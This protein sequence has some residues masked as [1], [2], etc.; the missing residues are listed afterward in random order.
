M[1]YRRILAESESYNGIAR[2]LL[3]VAKLVLAVRYTTFRS[4]IGGIVWSNSKWPKI[5]VVKVTSGKWRLYKIVSKKKVDKKIESLGVE[6]LHSLATILSVKFD[7][8]DETAPDRVIRYIENT[9]PYT[10]SQWV[11]SANLD[12]LDPQEIPGSVVVESLRDYDLASLYKHLVIKDNLHPAI[13]EDMF[14]KVN[15]GE[16]TG[17][18]TIQSGPWTIQFLD[19]KAAKSADPATVENLLDTIRKSLQ[20]RG[21]GNLAYGNVMV[22]NTLK[23]GRK[24]A[25]YEEQ[26][27][28]IRLR[29]KALK[30]KVGH[31]FIRSIAHELAHRNWSKR[32]S[33]SDKRKI[34]NIYIQKM[35]SSKKAISLGV[36]DK[37]S[38]ETGNKYEILG[39]DISGDYKVKML[40]SSSEPKDVGKTFLFRSQRVM[41]DNIKIEGKKKPEDISSFFP[42]TYSMKNPEEM[43]AELFA[44]WMI[45][46][47]KE[48]AKSWMEEIS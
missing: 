45:G 10:L 9:M 21:L 22:S 30:G 40:A 48:P 7:K 23:G 43:Y 28:M 13:F 47:L 31:D 24:L 25:D 42:T 6:D 2:Q 32:I 11:R 16:V 4:G 1:I 34:F 26:S 44:V 15:L 41:A 14:G 37:V 20:S 27:D 12:M 19:E 8:L 39:R 17:T 29:A 5:L 3:R 35:A 36:G 38:D 18:Q 33:I 46:S